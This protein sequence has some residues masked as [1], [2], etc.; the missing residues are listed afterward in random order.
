MFSKI[1]PLLPI[2]NHSFKTSSGISNG[3]YFHLS[4]FLTNLIS[5]SPRGEPCEE[6]FPDLL[7]DP[8]PITVLHDIMEG[9]FDLVALEIALDI[10]PSLCPFTSKKFQPYDSNLFL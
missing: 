10:C 1:S 3:L 7:G 2:S 5:S 4:F 8:K 9:L 6:A